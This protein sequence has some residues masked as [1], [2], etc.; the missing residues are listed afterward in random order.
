MPRLATDLWAV[1]AGR[2]EIDPGDLARAIEGEAQQAGLDYRTRLLTR[3]SVK[4]LKEHWGN[5]RRAAWLAASPARR[6]IE[7]IWAEDFERPGFPSLRGRLMA[8]TDPEDIRQCLRRLGINC[9][10]RVRAVIGGSAALILQ[11]YLSRHTEGI[12][13]VDEVPAEVRS[14]HKLLD[15][16][17]QLFGP[18]IAHFRSHYLPSGWQDRTHLLEPFGQL[19]ASVV[20]VY[21]IFLSKL[22]S[23]RTKDLGDLQMLVPQ[24]DKKVLS[25]R[26][27]DTRT[28]MFAAEDLRKHAEQ[29][30]YVLYGEALPT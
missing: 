8:K 18:H 26:L 4:A 6:Q 20:D 23:I 14:Q 9:H 12:D 11:G 25:R 3:D 30:W 7:A 19:L 5:E 2:P 13:F 10:R 17:Q 21:D 15:E 22:V 1:V 28:S 16:G 24:L 27:E 29:N